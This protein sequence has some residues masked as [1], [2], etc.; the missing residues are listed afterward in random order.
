MTRGRANLVDQMSFWVSGAAGAP[1]NTAQPAC[2]LGRASTSATV[3]AVSEVIGQCRLKPQAREAM[4]RRLAA[5][6]TPDGIFQHGKR[7]V[8]VATRR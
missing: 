4:A 6:M 2:D 3:Q 1:G 8:V 5:I 7:P